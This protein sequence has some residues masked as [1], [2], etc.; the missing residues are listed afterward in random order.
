MLNL[1]IN[2][3]RNKSYNALIE[4]CRHDNATVNDI[5]RLGYKLMQK[6]KV[7]HHF[8]AE[9]S[10]L[11]TAEHLTYYSLKKPL[12]KWDDKI[13]EDEAVEIIKLFEMRIADRLPVAYITHETIFCGHKFYVND[14]V[15]VPRSVMST[16]FQDFLNQTKWEN[17]SV[18]DLCTGSGCIGITLA[19]LKPTLQVDLA[20][21]SLKALEVAQ[22]NID[23]YSLNERVK[24][25]QSDLFSNIQ[26]K[27]D[28]IIS[29]PPYVTTCEYNESAQE[30]KK[31]PKIALEAGN[32]GLDII[33]KIIAEAKQHLNANGT[34]IVEVGPTAAK[35]IKKKYPNLPLKWLKVRKSN[36][37]EPFMG[38]YCIFQCNRR[39]LLS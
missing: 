11:S 7:F 38:A 24:C 6:E 15:L 28:L 2:E 18:L 1:S 5:I 21:I 35:R 9:G 3:D 29:N 32:D 23:K 17:N 12:K 27:Y 14:Q 34:L 39:D 33:N 4:S 36:G 10:L 31:E 19:L 16:R 22:I 20:D 25:I 8:F 37:K 13:T 26:N 30:F